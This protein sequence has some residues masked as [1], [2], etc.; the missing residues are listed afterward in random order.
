MKKER[1]AIVDIATIQQ[2]VVHLLVILLRSGS[3]DFVG[4][5][6][7]P[8]RAGWRLFQQVPRERGCRDT[9]P[10]GRGTLF[11]ARLGHSEGSDKQRK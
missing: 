9:A 3:H 4:R 10:Y 8:S 5:C 2:G 7:T 1:K 6:S 11:G